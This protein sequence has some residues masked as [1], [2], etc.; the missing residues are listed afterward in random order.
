MKLEK[1]KILKQMKLNKK[2]KTQKM[3][4][5]KFIRSVNKRVI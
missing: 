3:E 1:L 4:N 2:I 5:K